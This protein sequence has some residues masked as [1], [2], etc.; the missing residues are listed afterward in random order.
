MFRFK[1]FTIHQDRCA[2]KVCSDACVLGA[3][4][5]LES[6]QY[7]LDIGT[8]TGLL[9]LMAAQRNVCENRQIDAIEIE[10]A[11][12]EQAAENIANSP[13]KSAIHVYNLAVQNYNPSLGGYDY[14]IC[15]PPF[16][17]NQLLS[18][19]FKTNQA[20]HSVSLKHDELLAA[21]ARLLNPIG[22]L[23]V[24]LPPTQSRA[25]DLQAAKVG[26]HPKRSLLLK[27]NAQKP[28]FR[29]LTEYCFTV[30]LEKT[31]E[32]LDIYETE[33]P[34]YTFAYRSLLK[35]FYLNF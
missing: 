13:F 28:I 34:H 22:I 6:A 5:G 23:G 32:T 18:P 3:W 2:M 8:G 21:V 1:H 19:Q 33:H 15:N 26:L 27:H 7:I 14:V 10:Q 35:D 20:H 31:T 17:E 29:V 9:A 30:K 4:S 11:A 16:Y 12:A 24:L 25:F